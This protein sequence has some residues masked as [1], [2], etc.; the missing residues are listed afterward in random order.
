VT[1]KQTIRTSKKFLYVPQ[2]TE[3][4]SDKQRTK[5]GIYYNYYYVVGYNEAQR[6][7]MRTMETNG[8]TY[9]SSE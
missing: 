7:Y 1:D 2:S 4:N 3:D 5:V 6:Y 8:H 9:T